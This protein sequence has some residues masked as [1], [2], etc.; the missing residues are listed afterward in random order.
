MVIKRMVK[1]IKRVKGELANPGL[2]GRTAVKPACVADDVTE[3][4]MVLIP[5]N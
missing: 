5:K 2:T 1:V 4:E 3:C